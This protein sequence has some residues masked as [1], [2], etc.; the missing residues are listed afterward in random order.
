[1]L[2]G[3]CYNVRMR[4]YR[5]LG[6]WYMEIKFDGVVGWSKADISWPGPVPFVPLGIH[7]D[8]F[9]Q[10]I[11]YVIRVAYFSFGEMWNEL[12]PWAGWAQ[13]EINAQA[14]R[15]LVY[16][17]VPVHTYMAIPLLGT[18]AVRHL[19]KP[20]FGKETLEKVEF[21]TCLLTYQERVWLY[22]QDS[23]GGKGVNLFRE[24][25]RLGDILMFI[26][27]DKRWEKGHPD[28]MFTALRYFDYIEDVPI[29][30]ARYWTKIAAIY[31][32]A[33]VKVGDGVYRLIDEYG[34]RAD[35]R[36]RTLAWELW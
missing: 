34:H 8:V 2:P 29:P 6:Y 33:G 31:L 13:Q 20:V 7:E 1:M 21:T 4:I 27:R 18:K 25:G 9:R 16:L 36:A 10:W 26:S 11:R 35:L 5:M 14:Q 32:G 19:K 3:L 22:K 28:R 15:R 24:V 30:R 23:I 17:W 12:I